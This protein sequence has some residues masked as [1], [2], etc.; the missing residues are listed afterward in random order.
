MARNRA[1]AAGRDRWD[2]DAPAV[3]PR[4]PYTPRPLPTRAEILAASEVLL[5]AGFQIEALM[6]LRVMLKT[7][8]ELEALRERMMAQPI[9]RL[10]EVRD[11]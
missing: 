7:E 2:G 3:D 1:Q 5:R 9:V 8:H 11:G 10:S 4:D 6:V